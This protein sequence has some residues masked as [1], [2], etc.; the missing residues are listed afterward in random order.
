MSSA[1]IPERLGVFA[2]FAALAAAA[3]LLLTR[4]TPGVE[5]QPA[6][7]E[8]LEKALFA[9]DRLHPAVKAPA[10]AGTAAF[11][12]G[13]HPL[14]AH[15]GRR[16]IDA[17][18]NEHATRMDCLVC[19][20]SAVAG[21]SRPAPAW[22]VLSGSSF[23]AAL[24][25]ERATRERL[26][27]LRSAVTAGRRCFE[28]GPGCAGCHRSGGMALLVRPGTSPGRIAG[29]EQLENYFTLAPGEKWYFPQLK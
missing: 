6:E 5:V 17:M 4:G 9:G 19:H 20:W 29:L 1:G 15:G 10:P 3:L 16:V 23:F 14:P 7:L 18:A 11:C 22:Q 25:A 8:A 21:E 26:G 24:P 28:R 27:A 13:C 12:S 2:V